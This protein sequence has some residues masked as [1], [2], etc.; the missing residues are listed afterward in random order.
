M[1]RVVCFSCMI[2]LSNA[3]ITAAFSQEDKLANKPNF[4]LPYSSKLTSSIKATLESDLAE[5]GAGLI[6]IH[7]DQDWNEY[8]EKVRSGSSGIYLAAPHFAAWLIHQHQ[9]TPLR[10]IKDSLNYSIISRQDDVEIFALSDLNGEQVC[11][12]MPLSLD[13][14]MVDQV[15]KETA[16]T[17]IKA[18]TRSI[19]QRIVSRDIR[20]R[21]F[22]ASKALA[23][24]LEQN[25]P[26]DYARLFQSKDWNNYAILVS[27]DLNSE[28]LRA[29]D[30]ALSSAIISR[31]LLSVIRHE[32]SD[33]VMVTAAKQDYPLELSE[34]LNPYWLSPD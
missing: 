25:N 9:F 29:L 5:L 3:F 22:T 6:N 14:L 33:T 12:Q 7:T 31:A 24:R 30:D 16:K 11:T 4:Y 10:R 8:L 13:Y 17:V 27:K 32:I 21:G 23:S 20:C 1:R 28:R 34:M 15:L 26:N 2:L 19:E 18:V